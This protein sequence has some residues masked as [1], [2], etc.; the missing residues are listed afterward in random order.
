MHSDIKSPPRNLMRGLGIS[1][2]VT[3]ILFIAS[4]SKPY[5]Q[6]RYDWAMELAKNYAVKSAPKDFLESLGPSLAKDGYGFP[7]I[8][9]NRNFI[10]KF[11]IAA[12]E[13]DKQKY[14][15][16]DNQSLLENLIADSKVPCAYTVAATS[17]DNDVD[18]GN[19]EGS[20]SYKADGFELLHTDAGDFVF[21]N[22]DVYRGNGNETNEDASAV[23]II[24]DLS[25]GGFGMALEDHIAIVG[26]RHDVI[27]AA[28][29][30]A[31]SI[32]RIEASQSGS[33][34]VI[35]LDAIRF[36]L[37]AAKAKTL[38]KKPV[39]VDNEEM[40]ERADAAD[41]V[42]QPAV[43]PPSPGPLTK[44]QFTGLVLGKTMAEVR[45]VLGDPSNVDSNADGVIWFYWRDKLP[46]QDPDSGVTFTSSSIVFDP[47]TKMAI[48]VGF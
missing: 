10:G 19:R 25:D 6:N 33:A 11:Q 29:T 27:A 24:V 1:I 22:A 34:K 44:D 39:S 42:R 32:Q 43:A 14:L 15:Q 18:C 20:G 31:T 3:S 9:G 21:S 40:P 48:R 36:D 28:L 7:D 12:E 35:S 23:V 16:P 17:M 45:A 41:T 8:V 4:C 47:T 26:G 2:A 5:T 38:F 37:A 30:L 13:L 46:V